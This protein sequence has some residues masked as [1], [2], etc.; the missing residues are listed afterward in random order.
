MFQTLG[1]IAHHLQD[2]GQPQHVRNDRHLPHENDFFEEYILDKYNRQSANENRSLDR[3]VAGNLYLNGASVKFPRI[4]DFWDWQSETSDGGADRVGM[5]EYT[6]TNFITDDTNFVGLILD[7]QSRDE[8]PFPRVSEV[9]PPIDF[10]IAINDPGCD[11][12]ELD[13]N[14]FG[15]SDIFSVTGKMRWLSTEVIDGYL[16][17]LDSGYQTTNDKASAFSAWKFDIDSAFAVEPS[18]VEGYSV[19][20]CVFDKRV[21]Y[22]IPRAVAFTTGALDFFFRGKLEIGVPENGVYSVTD[23]S[24]PHNAGIDGAVYDNLGNPFGYKSITLNLKNIT[25]DIEL[26]AHFDDSETI[27]LENIFAQDMFDGE[28]MAVVKYQPN[29]CYQA[30][31]SGGFSRDEILEFNNIADAQTVSGC[32]ASQYFTNTPGRTSEEIFEAIRTRKYERIVKSLPVLIGSGHELQ[33]IPKLTPVEITFDFTSNPIPANARDV[34]LQVLYR[35]KMGPKDAAEV[36]PTLIEEDAVVVSSKDISEPA[37]VVIANSDNVFWLSEGYDWLKVEPDAGSDNTLPELVSVTADATYLKPGKYTAWISAEAT[38]GTVH[39]YGKQEVELNVQSPYVLEYGVFQDQSS[40]RNLDQSTIDGDIYAWVSPSTGI[41]EVLFFIDDEVLSFAS[42]VESPFFIRRD[43]QMMGALDTTSWTD[44]KHLLTVQVNLMSGDSVQF[45]TAFTVHNNKLNHPP[46]VS[47]ISDQVIDLVPY[48]SSGVP[49]VLNFSATDPDGDPVSMAIDIGRT[50]D[51]I[52]SL[53]FQDLGD[54]TAT[55][56]GKVWRYEGPPTTA[57]YSYP[58]YYTVTVTASDGE[59][60][61]EKTF[62][63]FLANGTE[64]LV[65]ISPDKLEINI[66]QGQSETRTISL[67]HAEGRGDIEYVLDIDT[68]DSQAGGVELEPGEGLRLISDLKEEL[69]FEWASAGYDETNLSTDDWLLKLVNFGALSSPV[70]NGEAAPLTFPYL[71]GFGPSDTIDV[72]FSSSKDEV[73]TSL[74]IEQPDLSRGHHVRIGYLGSREFEYQTFGSANFDGDRG[75]VS[76]PTGCKWSGGAVQ[77]WYPETN[78]YVA[79]NRVYSLSNNLFA[80]GKSA[81]DVLCRLHHQ[82]RGTPG[83]VAE[84]D[85]VSNMQAIYGS[86][87]GSD[88]VDL[89]YFQ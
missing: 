77:Q 22:T 72:S 7:P 45:Q 43:D 13:L 5:A 1:H 19:N 55:L 70:N 69:Q 54:G 89:D 37:E 25:K 73:A 35:G 36:D 47:E 31:G 12:S 63:L 84:D 71:Q 38:P 8:L 24:Y 17:V 26:P 76:T 86:F 20:T 46:V 79:T 65:E 78:Q 80:Q 68:F 33:E 32:S 30:D 58:S 11:R 41:S 64:P 62:K 81:K 56:S 23:L 67:T 34:V 74:H 15:V 21:I 10:N 48:A 3:L 14:S 16:S 6:S 18:V 40:A 28:L 66:S 42:S 29:F 4:R 39:V 83:I 57:S 60:S 82:G 75:S 88:K 85:V 51:G 49:T 2:M 52:G 44:G 61:D 50:L 87:S 59:L 27:N 53:A 9:S